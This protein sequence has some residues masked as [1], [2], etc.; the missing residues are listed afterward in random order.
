[1]CIRD[2]YNKNDPEGILRICHK[3]SGKPVCFKY[4]T[5]RAFEELKANAPLEAIV[6]GKELF[7][8]KGWQL[9]KEG[10]E[11]MRTRDK[12]G[13]RISRLGRNPGSTTFM[14]LPSRDRIDRRR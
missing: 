9:S 12:D 7:A 11:R 14:I 4:A 1:M 8:T 10:R 6:V 13:K 2:R 5:V 3:N